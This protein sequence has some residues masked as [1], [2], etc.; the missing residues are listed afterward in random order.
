M[1]SPYT[2]L[3]SSAMPGLTKRLTLVQEGIRMLRNTRPSLHPEL[4]K[5]LM[6]D[7][8]ERMMMSG[9][10]ADYRR[11]IIESAVKGYEAQVAADL[12]G[13]KPLYRPRSWQQETRRKRKRMKGAAWYRPADTVLFC[14]A[15]PGSEL[16]NKLR[17][18]VEEEGR[19]IN[20]RVRVVEKGGVSLRRQL[21]NTDL[22]AGEPCAAPSCMMC[23]TG[24]GGGGLKHHRAG[25][26]YHGKC[27]ICE[28]EGLVSEYWGESGDSAYARCLDHKKDIERKDLG[29]AFAKH[30]QLHHPAE[31]GKP[32]VFQFRLENTFQRPAPRQVAEAVKIHGSKADFLLNSKSEWEQPSVDRVT[33]TN[34]PRQREGG[35]RGGAGQRGRGGRRQVGGAT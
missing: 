16:A 20:L 2:I 7:L 29:N 35:G 30:I 3:N 10:N 18:V 33:I 5:G 13:E 24:G 26:L 11:G 19:R 14:P 22:A 6:E 32:E 17:E 31:E 28:A 9:Y 15:T 4:R 27:K 21:V 8:A 12:T 25:A 1:A 34:E 23:L